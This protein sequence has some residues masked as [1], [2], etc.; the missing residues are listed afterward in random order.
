MFVS[1]VIVVCSKSSQSCSFL[2]TAEGNW[3]HDYPDECDDLYSDDSAPS[4]SDESDP[5]RYSYRHR[6]YDGKINH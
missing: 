2:P 3:R 5:L 4:S 6:S 1:S